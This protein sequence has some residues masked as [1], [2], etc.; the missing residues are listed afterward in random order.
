MATVNL[1]NHT[2]KLFMEG[3]NIAAKT[4]K[5]MLLNSSA[6]FNATH[7][8]ISQVSNAG[9]YEVFGNGWAQGGMSL[10]AV[11]ITTID[12]N[13][14]MFDAADLLVNISAGNLGPY[15]YYVLYNFTDLNGPVLA[16]WT[17]TAPQTV[18]D[19]GIA[20][21]IWPTGGIFTLTVT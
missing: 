2:A 4:Y 6:S 21:V 19:G 8:T 14:A 15:S 5:I 13:D 9:T 18:A 11:T 20:G 1:F 10:T 7:T 17:L 16:F 12:T 3:S